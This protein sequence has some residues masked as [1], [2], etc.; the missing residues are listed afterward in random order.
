V[1]KQEPLLIY[2]EQSFGRQQTLSLYNDKVHA[3][4][5]L[6]LGSA[7]N[8]VFPLSSLKPEPEMVSVRNPA[9]K[10]FAGLLFLSL[11]VVGYQLM[12]SDIDLDSLLGCFIT[13]S[14]LIWLVAAL[15]TLQKQHMARFYKT[16]GQI[17]F[18]IVKTSKERRQFAEVVEAISQQIASAGAGFR[19]SVERATSPRRS[20]RDKQV[21]TD[22][23][24]PKPRSKRLY[25]M[26]AIALTLLAAVVPTVYFAVEVHGTHSALAK[27]CVDRRVM[28]LRWGGDG[29]QDLR[30]VRFVLSF[31]LQARDDHEAPFVEVPF[32]IDREM[33]EYLMQDLQGGRSVASK[34]R[35]YLALPTSLAPRR[36]E[37][38]CALGH[39]GTDGVNTL[40]G[41][42]RN[43]DEKIRCVAAC[44]LRSTQ[45][46]S[47]DVVAAF[48]EL[49]ADT[50]EDI[51]AVAKGAL[52]KLKPTRT[53]KN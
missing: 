22:Q 24:Q 45:A 40:L 16:N 7:Y 30:L 27:Y 51:R 21:T 37:A 46:D 29:S 41:L 5:K 2:E 20:N 44:A 31:D 19:M 47:D 9:F 25:L 14:P 13:G 28:T 50:S 4:G 11:G 39:C 26:W 1:S 38:I 33:H 48:E 52:E 42:V 35:L 15:A 36:M 10:V 18:L 23:P 17:A 34:L 32:V 12:F 3:V 53:Q 43:P 6:H 49:R 8:E